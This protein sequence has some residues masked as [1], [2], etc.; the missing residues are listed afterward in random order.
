MLIRALLI[1]IL[2]HLMILLSASRFDA[3][4]LSKASGTGTSVL[5]M[6][7]GLQEKRDR[8]SSEVS[9]P[10]VP[11]TK[12]D[13]GVRKAKVPPG[14]KAEHFNIG[15]FFRSTVELEGSGTMGSGQSSDQKQLAAQ[16]LSEEALGRYRLNLARSARQFK[17]Y[18]S[19]ARENGWEGVVVVSIVIPIGLSL[20][21]VS[22]GRS[23]GHAVLDRQALEMV[24][25]AVNLAV[26][27]DDVLGRGMNISL[28]VEYRLAD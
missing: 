7:V 5:E 14:Q 13:T 28:P 15:R 21:T 6:R 20:P 22:I 18:P 3:F 26:V 17:T 2:L 23:S 4:V 25:Q 24:E 8:H 1:S 10:G 9:A 19:L 11:Y 27:P 16:P 12:S